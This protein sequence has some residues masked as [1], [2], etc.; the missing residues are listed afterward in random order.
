M[1]P[2]LTCLQ[3]PTNPPQAGSD[4]SLIEE[5]QKAHAEGKGPSV[6]TV[7]VQPNGT[8][9]QEVRGAAGRSL[10]G[11]GGCADCACCLCMRSIAV[12]TCSAVRGS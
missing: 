1:C 12:G 5:A 2:D 10:E 3:L 4:N 8:Q 7:L 11:L 6:G 9:L